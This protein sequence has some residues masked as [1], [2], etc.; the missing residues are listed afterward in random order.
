MHIFAQKTQIRLILVWICKD[1]Y[2]SAMF[3]RYFSDSLF[4]SNSR[5]F[6]S[7]S[8]L[9]LAHKKNFRPNIIHSYTN[10][11]KPLSLCGVWRCM[12]GR[13]SYTNHTL[14]YTKPP[15]SAY[16]SCF[17]SQG[18]NIFRQFLPENTLFSFIFPSASLVCGGLCLRPRFWKS[19]DQKRLMFSLFHYIRAGR[20]MMCRL[21]L[22]VLVQM[23]GNIRKTENNKSPE[24]VC[25]GTC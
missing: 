24:A 25:L 21:V 17:T 6:S 19:S 7:F 15:F 20:Y 14:S 22:L 3:F 4:P 5:K 1:L 10:R 16:F 23:K 13:I 11:S 8:I 18:R 9:Q 2:T 12:M